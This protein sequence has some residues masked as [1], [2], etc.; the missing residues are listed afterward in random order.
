MENSY[1]DGSCGKEEIVEKASGKDRTFQRKEGSSVGEFYLIDNQGNLQIWDE[2]GYILTAKKTS[3]V[4]L[5]QKLKEPIIDEAAKEF[6]LRIGFFNDTD[7]KP[8]SPNCKMWIRGSG[9]FY[10]ARQEDWEFGG[11]LIEEAGPFDVNKEH[12]IYFYPD[13]LNES[14]VIAISFKYSAGMSLKGSVRD[15]LT[16]SIKPEMIIF[17]GISIK[18]ANDEFECKFNRKTCKKVY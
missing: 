16:I 18:N 10:P 12:T 4:L 14:K 9:D 7:K 11:T 2:E 17:E 3:T 13:Y 5:G 8:I 6:Y 1:K 15:M